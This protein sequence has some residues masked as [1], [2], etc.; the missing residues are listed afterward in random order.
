MNI[1]YLYIFYLDII[2]CVLWL[3]WQKLTAIF[4]VWSCMKKIVL[5][6]SFSNVMSEIK[7]SWYI[8]TK[9]K[10]FVYYRGK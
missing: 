10:I 9:D 5:R 3:L 1:Y 8:Y 2:A 7:C 6:R 4:Y